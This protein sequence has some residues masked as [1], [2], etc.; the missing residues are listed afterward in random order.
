MKVLI[1]GAGSVGASIAKE[2]MM[3]GHDVTI[4]DSKPEAKKRADLPG[5]RWH[6]GDACELSVRTAPGTPE[7]GGRGCCRNR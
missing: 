4:I 3:N 1:V 5:V 2:L 7:Q 6:I